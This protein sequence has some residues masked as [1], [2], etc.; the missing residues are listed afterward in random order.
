[1]SS[2]IREVKSL[3]AIGNPI[4]DISASLPKDSITKYKLSWGSTV[5]VSE[6]NLGIFEELEKTPG[7]TYIPGGSVQNS[8]RVCSWCL[9]SGNKDDKKEITMLGTTGDDAYRQKIIDALKESG[10]NDLFSIDKENSTSRC[11]VAINDK[12]RSL[13]TQIKASNHL[14]QEFVNAN[15]EKIMSHDAIIIE[16]YFLVEQFEICK[17]LAKAFNEQGKPVLFTLSAFFLLQLHPEKMIEI[18]NCSDLIFGNMEECEALAGKKCDDY[19]ETLKLAFQ[20]LSKR[21]RQLIITNGCK[22]TLVAKYN[23]DQDNFEYV[24]QGYP[25]LIK[26]EEIVD[27]NGAGD[28][29]L[30]GYVCQWMKGKSI[31]AC[32]KGGNAAAK[33]ILR[34]VGCTIDKNDTIDLGE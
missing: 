33:Y 30:G 17:N 18:A 22:P 2:K 15:M 25:D 13:A 26:K 23:Y 31:D 4:V 28:S 29:F 27:T 6:E 5:L 8:L 19:N 10:V 20:K 9:Q 16:G 3:I 32:V 11:G 34:H 12:E 24:F 14:S 1:M 7:V 21:N